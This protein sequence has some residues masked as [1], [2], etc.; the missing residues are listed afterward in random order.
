MDSLRG[1]TDI[2]N[3]DIDDFGAIEAPPMFGSS[4]RRMHVRAYNYW[5]SLLG[6]RTLPS[7]EDLNPED[8]QDFSANSV[9]LD[10]SMGLENPAILYLGSALREE[11]GI[12]G[13]I[14]RVDEVPARSLLTRLTDHYLQIIANAAP[15]GFEAEFINQ[16]DVSIRYR[17]ILMPFSSDDETIDFI[18]GV[19]NWKEAVSDSVLE[20][21][22]AEVEAALAA[23]PPANPSAPI[24]A[25][26][27]SATYDFADPDDVPNAREQ[28]YLDDLV[29]MT[30][31]NPAES[32]D[33]GFDTVDSAEVTEKL[34]DD[35]DYGFDEVGTIGEDP[36][37]A[38]LADLEEMTAGSVAETA[39]EAADPLDLAEFA[40]ASPEA[41]S[42]LDEIDPLDALGSLD[43]LLAMPEEAPAPAAIVEEERALD[44]LDLAA[45]MMDE[46]SAA[47]AADPEPQ[48]MSGGLDFDVDDLLGEL[49]VDVSA[50]DAAQ[51]EPQ[52]EPQDEVLE[53]LPDVDDIL[54]GME[55]DPPAAPVSSSSNTPQAEDEPETEP[56][57]VQ[58]PEKPVS[59][60]IALE[61][62][63]G[64]MAF[65]T[66]QEAAAKAPPPAP[67]P[68][69]SSLSAEMISVGGDLAD[70]LAEARNSAAEVRECDARS[71]AA[72][73]RAIGHAHDFALSAQAAPADY[74]EMLEDAGITVQERSPMTAVIKLVFGAD[75]DKTRIAEYA[76]ALDHANRQ[77]FAR[78]ELAEALGVYKGGL[79]GLVRDM[80][81][82]RNGNPSVSAKPTQRLER[83]V[84]KLQKAK[85]GDE[86]S[87]PF[88]DL[89]LAVVIARREV[90][91]SIAL[92]TG[93]SLE[94]KAAQKVM[95]AASKSIRAKSR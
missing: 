27:P 90:D 19:I 83:A 9:L 85:I 37:A 48:A 62:L 68:A 54:A 45:F 60:E 53:D 82:A 94:D 66:P 1:Q 23:P 32:A 56:A 41:D 13:A 30:E 44:E 59:V 2:E 26:G 61:D 92:L 64:D 6:N 17:G 81:V 8:T 4:E 77:G 78:G 55:I 72:L 3:E 14:E 86:A 31:P 50:A 80:R 22:G 18:Y 7:I 29:D 25:D 36:V 65:D 70:V 87:L 51:H 71:R 95:I 74:A 84:R 39:A 33:H 34:T 69:F 73:Y 40:V 21:L 42:G 47:G 49:T 79:K 91:G 57:P 89:G 63:L 15:V 46:D 11:C 58:M 20:Q 10:F 35:G 24:W 76:L 75:Y 93:V 88:G 28:E 38:A 5:V 67:E 43:D 12:D 52:H 16:R